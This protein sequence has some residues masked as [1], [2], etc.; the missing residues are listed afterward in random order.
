[1]PAMKLSGHLAKM[2]T[3]LADPVQYTLPLDDARIPLNPL[4]GRPLRIT[5]SGAI[6]CIHCGRATRKSFAQG[7][8]YPCFTRLAQC[9][10]CIV[11]PEQCHYAA[12]TCRE[13][14]WAADHCFRPHVVYLANAS[15]LKVGITRASQL[16]TRWLDQGASQA[17][18]VL[19]V[20]SRHLSG[21]VE[22][23]CKAH[24]SDRTQWQRML[25]GEP[26]PLDLP[27][28]RDDLLAR[29]APTLDALRA[30]HGDDA[31]T[32]LPAAEPV[33][34]RYPVRQWPAKVRA[35]NLDREPE[36]RGTLL[37]IKG[38]YLILDSGVLNIRKYGGY[39]VTVESDAL[40]AA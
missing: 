22:V 32:A 39:H 28:R 18:P 21:L 9:D 40:A 36:V 38:Q 26:Q 11:R 1:M 8:C 13:P 25:K 16:P 7:Y 4:L 15:G 23:A 14:D 17:L 3:A 6:H 33:A 37:G 2:H 27:A 24:V 29:I 35:L 34:I 19:E 30:E 5:H 10:T 20:R 12:G 31:V